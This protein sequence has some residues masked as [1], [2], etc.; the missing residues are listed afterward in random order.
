MKKLLFLVFLWAGPANA[1]LLERADGAAYYDTVLGITWLADTNLAAT[2]SFGLE[3]ENNPGHLWT[4]G[5]MDWSTANRWIDAMNEESYLGVTGWRMPTVSPINGGS[6]DSSV[7][8]NG[9]TDFG[10]NIGAS[11]TQYAGSTA[12][13]FASL[14]YNTLGNDAWFDSTGDYQECTG[15]PPNYC[16]ENTGPFLNLARTWYW[17]EVEYDVNAAF[18]FDFSDGQQRGYYKTNNQYVWAVVDGDVLP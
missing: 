9:S 4:T 11:G 13:E 12:S 16:L 1:E 7:T 5:V 2:E 17:T 15:N 8:T 14:Y 10:Y 3:V 18:A 6:F